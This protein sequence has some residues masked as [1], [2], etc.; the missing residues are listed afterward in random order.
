[1]AAQAEFSSQYELLNTKQHSTARHLKPAEYGDTSNAH[2][3]R[4]RFQRETGKKSNSKMR[5]NRQHSVGVISDH[6]RW[7]AKRTA[8]AAAALV[9]RYRR[10]TIR[11]P[12]SHGANTAQDKPTSGQTVIR[13]ASV[14][15]RRCRFK[16][17]SARC[18]QIFIATGL[19]F[20]RSP[21]FQRKDN[22]GS[23]ACAEEEA[24]R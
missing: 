8:G 7:F 17:W 20:K 3:L 1:M 4:A 11:G 9:C 15:T 18:S 24:R 23:G 21:S 16:K 6:R 22:A 10:F 19:E 5:L 14:N 2:R 13:R 12:V